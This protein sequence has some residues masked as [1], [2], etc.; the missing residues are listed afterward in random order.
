MILFFFLT[1]INLYFPEYIVYLTP[2]EQR[3]LELAVS[4]FIILNALFL[5]VNKFL[6]SLDESKS[7]EL[8]YF[9][10]L[11]QNNFELNQLNH[12]LQEN[13]QTL[14]NL[15]K[16]QSQLQ[17]IIVHDIKSPVG[18]VIN[19]LNLLTKDIEP[20]LNKDD[21]RFFRSIKDSTKQVSLV[22]ENILMM[23]KYEGKSLKF[24]YEKF[25]LRK[26]IEDEI[27]LNDTGAKLKNIDILNRVGEGLEVNFDKNIFSIVFRNILNNA[28]KYSN[29]N[30][31]IDIFYKE[32]PD[33]YEVIIKDYGIGIEKKYIDNI[34]Q[35]IE[36]KQ[37]VNSTETSTGFGLK[38]IKSLLKAANQDFL[39]DSKPE[40]GTTVTFTIPK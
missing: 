4:I 9:E 12:E 8:E 14:R 2:P 23:T 28:I 39:I 40:Q 34:Y 16:V 33:N 3:I 32:N 7:N 31:K 19:G 35:S 1:I 25:K 26:Q 29:S 10:K 24:N 37:I 22:I 21:L 15:N 20:N 13:N 5:M 30:S 6:I 17:T 38:I 11:K 27:K 36:L 18:A